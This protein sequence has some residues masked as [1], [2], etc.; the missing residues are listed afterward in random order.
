[1]AKKRSRDSV[2][3]D[4]LNPFDLDGSPEDIEF[5]KKGLSAYEKKVGLWTAV[6]AEFE[7]RNGR[8]HLIEATPQ[9]FSGTGT[10]SAETVIKKRRLDPYPTSP[11]GPL[12]LITGSWTDVVY[13][14]LSKAGR[15]IT[16]HELRDAVSKTELGRDMKPHEKPYYAGIQA[17]KMKGYC[18]AYKGR[19][20]TPDTLKKYLEDVA[21]GRVESFD[22]VPRFNSR[23][24]DAITHY[25]KA[26]G[27]WV[28]SKE[29]ADH[30][31]TLPEFQGIKNVHQQAC[32]V[33]SNQMYR[34]KIYERR[35]RAASAQWRFVPEGNTVTN[36]SGATHEN[37]IEKVRATEK[38]SSSAARH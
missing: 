29:I 26:R 18:V 16:Y 22:D 11:T 8:S 15:P 31:S 7:R 14:A 23:W 28:S 4:D 27:D 32:S 2:S 9:T 10:L 24:G 1:M 35:G 17:L 33:L 21:A 37:T 30:L 34:R 6:L 38:S 13:Q 19:V 36:G 25:L 20:A 5:I 3:L 12:T